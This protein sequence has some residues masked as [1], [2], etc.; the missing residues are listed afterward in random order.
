LY[1]TPPFITELHPLPATATST[2]GSPGAAM[3]IGGFARFERADLVFEDPTTVAAS[4]VA[5]RI[6]CSGVM[7]PRTR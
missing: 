1:T 4:T 2:L 7:P 5:A 3:N 6:A